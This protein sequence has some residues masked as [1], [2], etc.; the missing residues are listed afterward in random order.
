MN[1][2]NQT[3][4]AIFN[5]TWMILRDLLFTRFSISHVENLIKLARGSLNNIYLD[6][7][8]H[9]NWLL[10]AYPVYNKSPAYGGC[11]SALFLKSV[12]G[13]NFVKKPDRVMSL[14]Q[15]VALVM[16]NKCVKFEDS[17]NSM[18]VIDKVKVCGRSTCRCTQHQG[19]D[20]SFI[21]LKASQIMAPFCNC[22]LSAWST[23]R[24]LTNL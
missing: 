20:N 8:I 2:L 13:H 10:A 4:S 5:L 24:F 7:F 6:S 17:F 22:L 1:G 9:I 21:F 3:E 16:V 15:I 18:E 14:C 23:H 12:K 19:Y 11:R